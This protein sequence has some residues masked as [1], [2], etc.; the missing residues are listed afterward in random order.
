MQSAIHCDLNR[1]LKGFYGRFD[2]SPA[3][4][5]WKIR[6]TAHLLRAMSSKLPMFTGNLTS[7][8]RFLHWEIRKTAHLLRRLARNCRSSRAIC[9]GSFRTPA[10]HGLGVVVVVMVVCGGEGGDVPTPKKRNGELSTKWYQRSKN[11]TRPW[12]LRKTVARCKKQEY[13]TQ[14]MRSGLVI[15][16]KQ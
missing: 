4:L 10:V 2:E 11:S 12:L 9:T 1:E 5:H 15:V 3:I 7:H 13:A 8:L 14:I 16:P 6:K